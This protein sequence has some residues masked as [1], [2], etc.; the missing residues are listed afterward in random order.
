M[1][2]ETVT[3]HPLLVINGRIKTKEE[4]EIKHKQFKSA[5]IKSKEIY[6][7]IIYLTNKRKFGD[8]LEACI[9]DGYNI[10]KTLETIINEM[11]ADLGEN[12][13]K[14]RR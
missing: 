9:N 8:E 6:E 2:E 14:R 11:Q 13:V 5:L 7:K 1:N 4:R 12:N 10:R 3:G